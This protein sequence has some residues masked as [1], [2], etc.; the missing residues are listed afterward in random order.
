[1][2][3]PIQQRTLGKNGP[4][5]SAIGLGCM[6]M[7]DFYGPADEGESVATIQAALDAGINLLDTGD[8]Y[9]SGH[10]E[11]LV[12]EAIKGR[13][14]Q[15]FIQV[16]FGG[17][18][19]PDRSFLGFDAR[20]VAVKNFL[21]Y[22]LRRLNTDY[23]DLYQPARVDPQVPIEDTIGAISEMVKAGYV[24]H[25]GVSEVSA[26]TLRRAYAVHPIIQLQ[27]EYSIVTRMIEKEI[28][29]ATRE[30]GV[31]IT[32]YG[33]LSRGLLSSSKANGPSDFRTRLPRFTGDNIV[34]NQE[35]VSTLNQMAARK[36]VTPVQL[37]IAWVLAKSYNIIALAGSRKR[38]QLTE[39]LGALNVTL[40][41]KDLA[42]IET[43]VPPDA[44]AGT[45][46]DEHQMRMLD[47]E[48]SGKA[49]G[50]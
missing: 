43:T 11:L 8:F 3:E 7:S 22:S 49:Q 36:G 10:N 50:A 1:M 46:Y 28:L 35:L 37:A 24:R 26:D 19:G 44:I 5:V 47:S 25:I 6:G 31:G 18:R 34:K 23:I 12:R 27:I 2:S 33:I 29:P 48:K 40:T 32:A 39:A 17:M 13:R 30:L 42:E 4:V 9:G 21:T 14:A 16:K 38:N 41:P 20:P 15:A 45:R